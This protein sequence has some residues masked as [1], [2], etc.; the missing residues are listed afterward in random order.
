MNGRT[1]R[2]SIL[3]FVIGAGLMFTALFPVRFLV[4][5]YMHGGLF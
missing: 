4:V 5:A 2:L 3:A 1:I